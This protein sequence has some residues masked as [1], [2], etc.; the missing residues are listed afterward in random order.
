MSDIE[1]LLR[2]PADELERHEKYKVHLEAWEGPYDLLLQVIEDQ[3]LSLLDL[4]ISKLLE[5]YLIYLEN[6]KVVD[7]DEAGEFLVVAATLAQIKSK[8][9]LPKE[10]VP[11]EEQEKDPRED[12][13]RYLM[14]YQKIKAA[15]ELLGERPV[16]GRDVFV[17]G[18][19]E[20]FEGVEGEG[21][22]T[23]FQ[24][25]KGFQKAIRDLGSQTTMSF[26]VEPVSVSDRMHQ[27][28][29]ECSERRELSF[30]EVLA[31]ANSK[32][33]VI[34]SFLGVLELVRLKK[35]RLFASA[36]GENLF[37]RIV[38]GAV[39]NVSESEFDEHAE[40][41]AEGGETAE[42]SSTTEAGAS[43]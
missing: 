31:G 29:A 9:L 13:V 18:A 23:L 43:A 35:I 6:L 37:L 21:R 41:P 24:L 38:D 19:K 3:N 14:E 11:A 33:Y 17:K 4:D 30:A 22:G 27:I 15:A 40:A 36:D 7:I 28:F 25:V 8:L 26:S 42:A 34:A 1:R 12:L 5:H 2:A 20:V 10:E 32:V 39:D 16:L